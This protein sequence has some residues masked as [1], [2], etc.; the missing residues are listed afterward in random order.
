MK[1]LFMVLLSVMVLLLVGCTHSLEVKNLSQYQSSTMNTLSRDM[2]MG[3]M[4]PNNNETGQVLVTGTAQA[5]GGYIGKVV[6]PYSAS[7]SQ[8][9][10]VISKITIRSDH[11]G[12][13]YNFWINFPGFLVWAPAW[14]GYVY[15]PSYDVDVNMLSGIDNSTIDSFSIPIKLDVRHAGLDRTWTELSWLE[16]GIIAFVGGIYCMKY[17]DDVTPLVEAAVQKPVGDFIAQEIAKR[18]GNSKKYDSLLQQRREQNKSLLK[19]ALVLPG[20]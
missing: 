19:E 13:G 10:D 2:T 17:D 20:S 14:N 6:Y 12:S 16:S 7:A 5:L 3:I 18:L 9:V 11:S 15:E 1:K 4:T 8:A